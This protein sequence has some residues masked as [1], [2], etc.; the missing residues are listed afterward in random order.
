MEECNHSIVMITHVAIL[1]KM[2]GACSLLCSAHLDTVGWHESIQ[3]S[4]SSFH[5]V[6][7]GLLHTQILLAVGKLAHLHILVR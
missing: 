3:V 1:R 6:Q 2:I 4:H 7:A 5:C